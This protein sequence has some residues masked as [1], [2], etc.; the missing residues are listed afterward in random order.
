[1]CVFAWHGQGLSHRQ[2]QQWYVR[3]GS[4][5]FTYAGSS[6]DHMCENRDERSTG[7]LMKSVIHGQCQNKTL[8]GDKNGELQLAFYSI[9]FFALL[10]VCHVTS[11][12]SNIFLHIW[13]LV[14]YFS[15]STE[16]EVY[17]FA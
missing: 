15:N 10:P 11:Y 12:L 9:S 13:Q 14:M 7:I 5:W 2:S 3:V 6:Y 16:T 8:A 4:Q 17:A 1:M